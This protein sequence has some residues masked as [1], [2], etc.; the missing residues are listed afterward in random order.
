MLG[1]EQ[2]R[3]K[4]SEKNLELQ[5][6]Y[7]KLDEQNKSYRDGG[8]LICL[9]GCANLG[10]MPTSNCSEASHY[11]AQKWQKIEE[12]LEVLPKQSQLVPVLQDYMDLL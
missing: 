2:L 4:Q 8:S 1:K 3:R 5:Q 12:S 9:S 10:R 6:S 11:T 7:E